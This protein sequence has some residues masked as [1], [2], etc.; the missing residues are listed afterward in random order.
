MSEQNGTHI[1]V[2]EAMQH[3]LQL[4]IASL[5]K[6]L[7]VQKSI[8]KSLEILIE[9]EFMIRRSEIFFD[10][11]PEVYAAVPLDQEHPTYLQLASYFLSNHV[12][13]SQTEMLSGI[14]P[15]CNETMIGWKKGKEYKRRQM[16]FS[17]PEGDRN[18]PYEEAMRSTDDHLTRDIDKLV[19]MLCSIGMSQSSIEDILADAETESEHPTT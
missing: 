3:M 13:G 1:S 2:E 15:I 16:P 5:S 17:D 7:H 8:R 12:P 4:C 18:I 9:A 19:N 6:P 14:L 11:L 10:A